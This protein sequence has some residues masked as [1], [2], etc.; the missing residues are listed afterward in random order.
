MLCLQVS[1]VLAG[2]AYGTVGWPGMFPA[3]LELGIG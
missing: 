2:P 1:R 3:G